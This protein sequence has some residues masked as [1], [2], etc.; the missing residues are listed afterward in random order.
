M[1][2]RHCSSRGSATGPVVPL[3]SAPL[4]SSLGSV[5]ASISPDADDDA[6][7]HDPRRC[8]LGAVACPR[9]SLACPA[10]RRRVRDRHRVCASRGGLLE[11]HVRVSGGRGVRARVSCAAVSCALRGR[12][13]RV[14]RRVR[15]RGVHL[16]RGIGLRVQLSCAAVSCHVRSRHDVQRRVCQRELHV[17][18]GVHVRVRLRGRA[19][20]RHVRG[21]S[22]AVRRHV[23]QRHVRV[24]ARQHL[25]V[26]LP[27][28]QLHGDVRHRLGVH[29][30]LSGWDGRCPGL[31][32]L[33]VRGR[34]A[35]RVPRRAVRRV[36]RALPGLKIP[37]GRQ[38]RCSGCARSDRA[39]RAL[40]GAHDRTRP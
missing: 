14:R 36:R 38:R 33:D 40:T 15:Q 23:C 26:R 12:Q 7:G 29:P 34:G 17:R 1:V 9:A 18:S 19:V 39:A 28:R 20:S 3:S 8:P 35:D 25:R 21:R 31:R 13:S 30:H 22:S 4:V 37:L 32:V 5:V 24:W 27:R 2:I 11:R 6:S 10:S 16:R